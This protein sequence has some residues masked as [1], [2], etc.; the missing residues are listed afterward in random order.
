[1]PSSKRKLLNRGDVLKTHPHDEYWGCAVVLTARDAVD[2][3]APMCHI[4]VTPI[5]FRHDFSLSELRL[6]ALSVLELERP[7]RPSINEAA[8]RTETCIAIYSRRR[9]P[10]V[11]VIGAV[12]P[13]GIF[14]RELDFRAGNGSDGGWPFSGRV[15]PSLGSEAV[16]S[17]RAQHDRDRWQSEV[18]AAR[19]SHEEMLRR[20]GR[21]RP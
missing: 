4:A 20:I 6:D 16:H 9:T 17:W 18:E 10:A 2:S 12:D 7:V 1:V 19:S 11:H 5:V 8:Q 3:M 21:T 13:G 14:T 15:A